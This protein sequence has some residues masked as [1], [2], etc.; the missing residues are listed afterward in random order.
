MINNLRR[1]HCPLENSWAT[2][3][4]CQV[5]TKQVEGKVGESKQSNLN[6]DNFL[7]SVICHRFCLYIHHHLREGEGRG[8]RKPS[9]GGDASDVCGGC[10]QANVPVRQAASFLCQE[11]E[12][13][14]L[15]VFR[16]FTRNF[17]SR[18]WKRLKPH[19]FNQLR[20]VVSGDETQASAPRPLPSCSS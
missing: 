12:T 13:N 2:N 15:R 7:A 3:A 8:E 17:D 1:R 10:W 14:W 4:I 5:C 16:V 9:R 6:N 18:T 19:S 11:S 20:A